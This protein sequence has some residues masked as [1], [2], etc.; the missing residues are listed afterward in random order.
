MSSYP[1]PVLTPHMARQQARK[2][3]RLAFEMLSPDDRDKL[4]TYAREMDE[5]AAELE[6]ADPD[7]A[8]SGITTADDSG[9]MAPG[10]N[11]AL[12]LARRSP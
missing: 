4:L 11:V 6:A 1:K 8:P 5:R 2:A 3:R 9:A 10:D 7:R 12:F